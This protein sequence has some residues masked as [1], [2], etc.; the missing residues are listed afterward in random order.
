VGDDFLKYWYEAE[1]GRLDP[2]VL[3]VEG[4]VQTKRSRKKDIGPL[5][6]R[7]RRPIS[8]SPRTSGLTASRQKPWPSWPV[9]LA[10]PMAA[11][12]PC[13][14]TRRVVWDSPTIWAGIGGR[15]RASRS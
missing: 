5:S 14:A 1:A 11:S 9:G 4:S 6:E 10:P 7:I 2:F 13:P 15:K 3:V 8:P 12:T